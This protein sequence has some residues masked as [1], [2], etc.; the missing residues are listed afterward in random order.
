MFLE[1]GLATA[2]AASALLGYGVRGRSSQLLGPSV[3]RGPRGK[4]RIALT[5][6]D[7]PSEA[8]PELL[9]ILDNSGARATFFQC[10]LNV[11][12]L[13]EIAKLVHGRGHEIGNHTYS[14]PRLIGCTEARIR[15]EIA[16]T[17][18]AITDT[19]GVAPRLFRA[20]YGARWFGLGPVLGEHNLMGVMWTVIGYD[21]EWESPEIARF[22]LSQIEDGGIVCLHDGDRV[23]PHVD[24]RKTL[25]AVRRIV[26]ELSSHGFSCVT[27]SELMSQ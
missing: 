6:D 15:E 14:H 17:Q 10:G 16:K 7:G 26:P 13:P 11:E 23:S 21:W 20:P 4:R 24:R 19:V 2:G 27:V 3:W 1:L 22:V 5:F 8:T 9:D 12:R 18:H 25:D